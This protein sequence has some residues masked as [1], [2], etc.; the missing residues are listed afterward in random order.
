MKLKELM[1]KDHFFFFSSFLILI[2]MVSNS[3][4]QREENIS[5]AWGWEY[6]ILLILQFKALA[7]MRFRKQYLIPQKKKKMHLYYIWRE[8]IQITTIHWEGG[9]SEAVTP[10]V[11]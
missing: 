7:Q 11:T 8:I 2:F 4:K 10:K 3:E 5:K 1:Q 9:F 6:I